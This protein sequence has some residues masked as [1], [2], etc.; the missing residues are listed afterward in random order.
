MEARCRLAR[1]CFSK[2]LLGIWMDRIHHMKRA[3][4][5]SADIL[6]MRM[7]QAAALTTIPVQILQHQ[8][9]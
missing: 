6:R 2:R 1:V 9:T 3:G 4:Q 5:G 7:T 8:P